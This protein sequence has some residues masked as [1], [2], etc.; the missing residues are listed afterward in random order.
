MGVLGGEDPLVAAPDPQDLR[1]VV[2]EGREIAHRIAGEILVG[3]GV[4]LD[5]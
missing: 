4:A 2:T 3:Q 5:G 1:A